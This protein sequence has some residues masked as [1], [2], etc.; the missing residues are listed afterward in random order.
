MAVFHPREG[1]TGRRG[2]PWG[3]PMGRREFLRLT[4]GTTMGLWLAACGGGTQVTP[5]ADDEGGVRIGTP[6]NPVTQ[7]ITDDNP[8]IESD[9]EPEAGPLRVFNWADYIWP[10][11]L[12]D[13]KNEYEVEV[14][15]T[16]FYNLEEAIRKLRSDDIP[17]DVFFPTGENIPK[18]IAGK[19]LQ[20]L[21]PFPAASLHGIAW[22]NL[23]MPDEMPAAFE[24]AA[25][26][27]PAPLW[28]ANGEPI[29]EGAADRWSLVELEGVRAPYP[30]LHDLADEAFHALRERVQFEVGWDAL[31]AD[32]GHEAG[33]VAGR[34]LGLRKPHDEP[35]VGPRVRVHVPAPPGSRRIDHDHRE[36]PLL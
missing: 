8:P 3:R 33:A 1:W 32:D 9:L 13:F 5:R 4:G 12:R 27:T 31:A 7:P 36:F 21:T 25:A 24:Q 26:L 17:Y 16:T 15:L 14:E 30:Q 28:A 29:G 34:R 35:V 20:P 19:L 10:R 11:V 18:L 22:A 6:D 2:W 23:F